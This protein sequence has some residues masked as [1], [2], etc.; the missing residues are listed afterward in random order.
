MVKVGDRVVVKNFP[1]L[2][3]TVSRIYKE[4]A[5]GNE[6]KWDFETADIRL[7]LDW[8]EHGKSKVYMHD[9]NSVWYLYTATN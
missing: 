9:E 7:E 3:T 8:G 6:T 4:D 2:K 1:H 5:N